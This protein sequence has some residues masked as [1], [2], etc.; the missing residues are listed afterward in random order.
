MTDFRRVTDQLSV[1]PQIEVA[2]VEKARAQG[3]V[4]IVNNR[5]D[6][7]SPDQTPSGKIEEAARAAGLDYIHIPVMGGP[8]EAQAQAMHEACHGADGPVLAY[9]RSGTRS[10][11]TWAFGEVLAGT[12]S[13]DELA[14]RGAD[15]GYDLRPVLGV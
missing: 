2:D 7:E 11:T 10:I 8:T 14:E 13:R 12:T 15:A 6:G 3:F 5:P 9:C 4:R 1:A